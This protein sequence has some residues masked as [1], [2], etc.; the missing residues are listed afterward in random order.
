MAKNT[1]R[2][3]TRSVAESAE[4]TKTDTLTEVPSMTTPVKMS[5]VTSQRRTTTSAVRR[6]KGRSPGQTTDVPRYEPCAACGCLT[7]SVH[8]CYKRCKMCKQVRDAGKCDAFNEL[9]SLLRSKVDKNDLTPM[10]QSVVPPTE[11][12][13]VPI[14]PPQLAE[15]AVDADCLFAFAGEVKWPEDREM[16]FMSTT[17]IVEGND[18]SLGE[19]EI[20]EVERTRWL[21]DRGFGFK[22]GTKRNITPKSRSNC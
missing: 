16:G 5:A 20:G 12:G 9:A 10:L 14:G 19:N 15:P 6:R 7:H 13:L 21:P 18:R 1:S 11:T 22:L 17:E 8:Y 2:T 3:R 4:T